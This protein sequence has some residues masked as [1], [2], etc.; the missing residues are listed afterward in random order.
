[1]KVSGQPEALK[2]TPDPGKKKAAV[3][4]EQ[5]AIDNSP[6]IVAQRKYI[7]AV[8]P[9]NVQQSS[10]SAPGQVIQAKLKK[11]ATYR[12]LIPV[13]YY[14]VAG[15]GRGAGITKKSK[16][17]VPLPP[18]QGQTVAGQLYTVTDSYVDWARLKLATTDGSTG[19]W[20][21][22]D[23]TN[24]DQQWEMEPEILPS[25]INDT[26]PKEMR[27][28]KFDKHPMPV[29]P[30]PLDVKQ[31]EAG[32]CW[33]IACMAA[34]ASSAGWIAKLKQS[35]VVHGN[36]TVTINLFKGG[37]SLIEPD[38]NDAVSENVIVSTWLPT[39]IQG[40][41]ELIFASQSKNAVAEENDFNPNVNPHIWPA[42]IEKG[43]AALAENKYAKLDN[44]APERG[45][46][47]LTG[48]KGM[49]VYTNKDFS[50]VSGWTRILAVINAD[51][52]G[53]VSSKAQHTDMTG[54]FDP[55]DINSTTSKM[56]ENHVYYIVSANVGAKTLTVANPHQSVDPPPFTH[57]LAIK[58]LTKIVVIPKP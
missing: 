29:D 6:L 24:E 41:E 16:V 10:L 11:T 47:T 4:E 18:V 43:V 34:L 50:E 2:K 52:A 58:Y 32:D 38:D 35:I 54:S 42:L 45:I 40:Q 5:S 22:T 55:M 37:K 15:G 44:K 51:G 48:G 26:D 21:E 39:Y 49:E 56:I 12:V 25:I 1:M 53:T 14:N 30:S 33:L 19:I 9:Q 28:K 57:D 27:W 46:A 20:I 23:E 3:S 7:E 36:G 17:P 8:F 13:D 31:G